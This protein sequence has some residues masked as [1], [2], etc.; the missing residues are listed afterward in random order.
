MQ[1]GKILISLLIMKDNPGVCACSPHTE[2]L[3]QILVFYI[4]W[5]LYFWEIIQSQK[6]MYLRC[7]AVCFHLHFM[8][9][10][11]MRGLLLTKS[12]K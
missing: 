8:E 6:C 1:L 9:I 3:K 11:C 12:P 7:V 4:S 5:R 2:N 10:F